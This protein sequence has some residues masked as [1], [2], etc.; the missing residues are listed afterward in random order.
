MSSG[1]IKI[2]TGVGTFVLSAAMVVAPIPASAMPSTANFVIAADAGGEGG[3]TAEGESVAQSFVAM[4]TV[5]TR[6]QGAIAKNDFN[7]AKMEFSKFE[8]SWKKVEG[9]VKSKNLKAYD[10]IEANLTDIEKGIGSKNQ[11]QTLMV[12]KALTSSIGIASGKTPAPIADAGG[13]GGE[14][15][16]GATTPSTAAYGKDFT[17]K[18]SGPV[19]L[20]ALRKGGHIIY[21]R[22]A[23]TDKDYADQA[24]PKLD[25]TNCG[26]QRTLSDKGWAQ[27]KN[28]GSGFRKASIP[29]GKVFASDYCRAWQTAD[30]AFG[31]FKRTSALNFA[32]SEEYNAAQRLEMKT[33][34]MPL[35]TAMPAIGTNTVIV[36]HDDVFDA[37]TGYYPKPQGM[38]YILKPDGKKFTIV[39]TVA[40]EGWMMMSK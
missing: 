15:G 18:I 36:G 5:V 19:L 17:N 22:H 8:D 23:Q 12:L 34:V 2:W 7:M 28:I 39:A 26:T 37:A 31:T 3:E 30:L 40:A 16:E 38:A 21:I 25:L 9:G 6:T 10:A 32:K 20:N 14:G 11:S 4:E 13:E 35:L 27:A 1:V 29:V 33:A 24:D